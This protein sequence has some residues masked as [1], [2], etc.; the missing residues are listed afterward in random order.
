MLDCGADKAEAFG[1]HASRNRRFSPRHERVF[2]R[3]GIAQSIA[4]ITE[5]ANAML[6]LRAPWL[7]RG[8]YELSRRRESAANTASR[9]LCACA[10]P[11]AVGLALYPA[12]AAAQDSASIPPLPK[13]LHMIV[14]SGP[15]VGPDFISR[16][17]GPKLGEALRQNVIVENRAGSNGIVGVQYVARAPA[18]GSVVIMGNAG[19]HAVNAALYKSLP[20]DPVKDFAP[21]SEVAAVPLALIVHPAVPAKSVRELIAIARGSPGKLNVAVAGAAGELMGN[22]FMLQAKI[23]MKNIPY[24]GGAAASL[25]V[26]SGEADLVLTST[27][28]VAQQVKAGKL[29]ILGVTGAERLPLIA[30]VPTI[31]ESGLPGYDYEQWYAMFAPAKMPA[32]I[33]QALYSATARILR[34]PDINERLVATGHR[35]IGSTPQQ[36]AD[37]VRSEI[38]RTRQ[39]MRDSGMEQQ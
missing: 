14:A 5:G 2:V 25:A 9:R 12:A 27:F 4:V 10:L 1:K 38:E 29:R 34:I 13:V 31:A 36:L 16:L 18:D 7:V 37:K 21:I 22:A 20:Y 15:G 33:V 19:T 11:A 32:P 35:V 30:D 28:I 26:L 23:D 8:Q 24:K 17:I 3:G 39:I 6:V